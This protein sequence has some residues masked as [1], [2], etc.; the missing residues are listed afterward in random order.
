[1]EEKISQIEATIKQNREKSKKLPVK[2][3]D[4]PLEKIKKVIQKK[5]PKA[6]SRRNVLH[7]LKTTSK[8]SKSLLTCHV[9]SQQVHPLESKKITKVIPDAQD[10]NEFDTELSAVGIEKL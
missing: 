3:A 5:Y 7:T 4:N 6:R 2:I 9:I 1:M 10:P 8:P